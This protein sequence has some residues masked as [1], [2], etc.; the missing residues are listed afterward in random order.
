MGKLLKIHWIFYCILI[1]IISRMI[2]LYQFELANNV[3]SH[4]HRDFFIAMCKYDCQ[5]YLTIINEGY[6][7]VPRVTPKLWKGLANFAFFPLYPLIVKSLVIITGISAVVIG[8]VLN[9]LIVLISMMVFYLYLKL[10]VDE[11]NSRFGA[12]L[13]AFSPFSIYF[14][15]L[16]TEALFLLLSLLS[17]YFMRTNRL[18]LSAIC[19]GFL[20]A[21]RPLGVMF[22]LPFLGHLGLHTKITASSICK[23]AILSIISISGLLCYMFYLHIHVGDFLAFHHIQKGWGR[24][25]IDMQNL[26]S[27]LYRM[28]TDTHNFAFFF[29]SMTVSVYLLVKRHFAEA[30]F[31]LLCIL[32]GAMTGTMLSEARFCGT[33]FT[34]YFGLVIIARKSQTL[35]L[36]L[37]LVF[38]LFYTSYFLYW[39]A[40]AR[41]LI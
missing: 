22:S 7:V 31:N 12:L 6:D 17:F 23:I 3:M 35:K 20:S 38:I 30:L 16:Y 33:L 37:A 4:N 32:P 21:T 5:W 10:F 1:F 8:V 11:L 9:Q 36:L 14:A 2:M 25:G 41:F 27:Q 40:R 26:A 18:F 24:H 13:L 28:V 15:S 34:L 29:L 19:G 39:L